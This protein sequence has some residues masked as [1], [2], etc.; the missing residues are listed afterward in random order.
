MRDTKHKQNIVIALAVFSAFSFFMFS[1]PSQAT[2]ASGGVVEDPA[3][4]VT[5]VGVNANS[6]YSAAVYPAPQQGPIG[7]YE[8]YKAATQIERLRARSDSASPG[9]GAENL[10]LPLRTPAGN[11]FRDS[12][13]DP[14][15][16]VTVSIRDSG[17]QQEQILYQIDAVFQNGNAMIFLADSENVLDTADMFIRCG[18]FGGDGPVSA[19]KEMAE[20]KSSHGQQADTPLYLV[21]EGG[22]ESLYPMLS[23]LKAGENSPPYV[24]ID[25]GGRTIRLR[26]QGQILNVGP[27]LTLTLQNITLAGV[28]NNSY[29]LVNVEGGEL[30]LG[31]GAKITGNDNVRIAIYNNRGG[32][33][34][35][36]SGRLTIP[37]GGGEILSNGAI[38]G[39]G[40]YLNN[41]AVLAMNGGRISNNN[42]SNNGG[43]VYCLQNS[44]QITGTPKIGNGVGGPGVI[45]GN[46]VDEVYVAPQ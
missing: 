46:T 44:A 2:N 11:I 34:H 38:Y 1:C 28:P 39:G 40:V 37:D 18:S 23:A 22:E 17:G 41:G 9:S 43:G 15:L 26:S 30:V 8:D 35:V 27:G 36:E 31:S 42:A 24:T 3:G 32:G 4:I 45:A 12:G 13:E 25:G 10:E 29:A 21:M 33:V 5:L 20:K 16:M 6:T 7:S 14:G 19:L